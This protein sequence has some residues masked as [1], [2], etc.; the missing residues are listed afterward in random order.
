[1]DT[2]K[3]LKR[4]GKG[5]LLLTN[6]ALVTAGMVVLAMII[7]P[8]E[9]NSIWAYESPA[10]MK[11]RYTAITF[12]SAIAGIFLISMLKSERFGRFEEKLIALFINFLLVIFGSVSLVA[13]A[14]LIYLLEDDFFLFVVATS[15]F[16]ALISWKVFNYD[17]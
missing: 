3:A 7:D 15:L 5:L 2:K 14:D 12:F 6:W 8:G 16:S 13:I 4:T 9:S 1:M 17:L 11:F 10:Q